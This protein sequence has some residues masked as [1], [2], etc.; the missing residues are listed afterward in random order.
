MNNNGSFNNQSGNNGNYDEK[1]EIDTRSIYVGNVDY[2]VN[3]E[4]LSS[5]FTGCG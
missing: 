1:E 5:V 3:P 4:E 2:S